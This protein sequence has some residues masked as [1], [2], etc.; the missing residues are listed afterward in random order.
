MSAL[1]SGAFVVECEADRH[2]DGNVYFVNFRAW[3]ECDA[4]ELSERRENGK[5][6][7]P[8]VTGSVKWDGCINW[9]AGVGCM[10]HGCG[11][12]HADTI[13]AAFREVYRRGREML[14]NPDWEAKP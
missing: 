8:D 9:Q 4:D 10:A 1:I 13:A 2:A 6:A 14:T 11:P 12:H 5:D 3:L 7:E